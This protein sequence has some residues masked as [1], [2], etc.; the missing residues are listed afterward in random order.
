MLMHR[1]HTSAAQ[2]RPQQEEPSYTEPPFTPNNPLYQYSTINKYDFKFNNINT[3]QILISYH[4]M[5][6][7]FVKN[8][9]KNLCRKLQIN[10]LLRQTGPNSKIQYKYL[11]N[12]FMMCLVGPMII[13]IVKWE[14]E[15]K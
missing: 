14:I 5:I 8:Y 2:P 10:K 1:L 6:R 13:K 12:V 4:I 15:E 3:M 11:N 7:T 9:D